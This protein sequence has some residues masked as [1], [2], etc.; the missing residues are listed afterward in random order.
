M[1]AWILALALLGGWQILQPGPPPAAGGTN[2][3]ADADCAGYWTHEGESTDAAANQCTS[4]PDAHDMTVV[5]TGTPGYVASCMEFTF[6]DECFENTAGDNGG[7]YSTGDDAGFDST[8]GFSWGGWMSLTDLTVGHG[9]LGNYDAG[10]GLSLYTNASEQILC[11]VGNVASAVTAVGAYAAGTPVHVV[12]TWLSSSEGGQVEIYVDGVDLCDEGTG[13]ATCGS[14][15]TSTA[16]N[17]AAATALGV[18]QIAGVLAEGQLDQQFILR[19]KLTKTEAEAIDNCG[20]A[21]E[22]GC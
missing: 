12:C 4:D 7:E 17:G 18:S 3:S 6:G 14:T 13:T 1:K 8:T 20:F 10:I 16:G 2:W 22:G 15:T 21:N 9:I 5:F 19:Q 11:E